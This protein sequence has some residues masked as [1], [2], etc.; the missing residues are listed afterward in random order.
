MKYQ[1]EY[2]KEEKKLPFAP[3][4]TQ[5]YEYFILRPENKDEFGKSVLRLYSYPQ[6]DKY[7]YCANCGTWFLSEKYDINSDGEEEF[8]VSRNCFERIEILPKTARQCI[9]CGGELL[10]G[11]NACERIIA[12]E[13]RLKEKV[14]DFICNVKE[15]INLPVSTKQDNI[16]VAEY[17]THLVNVESSLQFFTRRYKD[18]II[19]Q[20]ESN[21][22]AIKERFRK[23][24][25]IDSEVQSIGNDM[26][27][28]LLPLESEQV[29]ENDL[30]LSKPVRAEHVKVRFFHKKEDLDKNAKI[31]EDY[32]I[33]VQKY[34][35]LVK[36]KIAEE[37]QNRKNKNEELRLSN[38]KIK[39]QY[40]AKRESLLQWKEEMVQNPEKTK[41]EY[42]Q[43]NNLYLSE[44][45]D[46]QDK[47]KEIG[48]ARAK[49]LSMN[50]VYPKYLDFVALTTISEYFDTGRCKQL[51]GPDGAYNLYESEIR[52]N[53]IIT[54]LDSVIESLEE[55]KNNQYKT[56]SVIVSMEKN[57][58][59]MADMLDDAVSS[60]KSIN[61]N[62]KVAAYY[63]EKT[64]QYSKIQT[65]LTN[66]LGFMV[67]F[68]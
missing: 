51:D 57:V 19:A 21:Q 38:E 62:T 8:Q 67:A 60:L 5:L 29:S 11:Y 48:E 42:A 40:E 56:Y 2:K 27:S 68:K 14:D 63:A 4:L 34:N 33:A 17:I 49:L 50:V 22:S 52:A 45:E 66:A 25:E 15:S 58:A 36:R 12:N 13:K 9:I 64:A 32:R 43:I 20:Y 55:V 53:R 23:I 1:I 3:N 24:K 28:A 46:I 37:V 61:D 59:R 10:N 65:E 44:I 18:L 31:E 39:A 41:G 16:N 35:E 26:S 54:Q 7:Q 47:I 30:G 6:E